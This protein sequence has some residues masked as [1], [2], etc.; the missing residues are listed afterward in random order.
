MW[1]LKLIE[2]NTKKTAEENKDI[3]CELICYQSFAYNKN[4]KT[5]YNTKAMD[6]YLHF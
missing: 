4:L 6:F 5:K 2:T 1:I 3:L